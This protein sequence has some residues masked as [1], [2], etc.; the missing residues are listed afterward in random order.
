MTKKEDAPAPPSIEELEAKG[1]APWKGPGP[2][3]RISKW[4]FNDLYAQLNDF[5]QQHLALSDDRYYHILT[6]WTLS[7]WR[8]EDWRAMGPLMLIGPV[9]SGK[10]TV[11]ECLEEVAYRGVRGGSMSNATMFRLSHEYTPTL[12]TR[13][14]RHFSTSVTRRAAKS[15]VW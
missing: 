10:T 8:V 11:L 9:S 5:F 7:T 1:Q 6:A 3:N 15:G 2:D 4:T 14:H 13:R 12:N